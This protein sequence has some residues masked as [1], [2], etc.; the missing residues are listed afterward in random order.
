MSVGVEASAL[1][2]P[3][4]GVD[5]RDLYPGVWTKRDP[6]TGEAISEDDE[7]YGDPWLEARAMLTDDELDRWLGPASTAGGSPT[8][9]PL[10]HVQRVP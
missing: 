10:T 4:S 7:L 6:V 8:T 2:D 1:A 3:T 9:P 5:W